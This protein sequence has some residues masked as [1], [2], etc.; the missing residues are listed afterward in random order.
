MKKNIAFLM[1]EKS[2]IFLR[3]K[4]KIKFHKGFFI[5]GFLILA[6]VFFVMIF[7]IR[8]NQEIE[9]IARIDS[10]ILVARDLAY[11]E[12]S[13]SGDLATQALI[14]SLEINYKKGQADSYRLNSIVTFL[15]KDYLTSIEYLE[16]SIEL[17]EEMKDSVG[18]ADANISYGHIYRDFNQR[19]KG[20]FHF[21]KAFDFFAK[22][23][24]PERISVT[25]Y[26]YANIL[27]ENGKWEK[28]QE[29]VDSAIHQESVKENIS[30]YIFFLNLRAKILIQSGLCH[31]AL[32]DLNLAK[33]KSLELKEN[34]NK[35]AFIET[36]F[37]L[38]KVFHHLDDF[39]SSEYYLN[40]AKNDP[41]ISYAENYSD[42]V[43]I[44]LINLNITKNDVSNVKGEMKKFLELKSINKG[45]NFYDNNEFKFSVIVNKNRVKE[46]IELRNRQ[47]L[48][49]LYSS[50]YL[51]IIFIIFITFTVYII[52]K[53]KRDRFSSLLDGQKRR[54][55]NLFENSPLPILIV[56]NSGNILLS[57]DRV[58]QFI[59]LYG[60]NMLVNL[61]NSVLN[62][63][64]VKNK[65][66][67]D[68]NDFLEFENGDLHI[69]VYFIFECN[70][71]EYTI[72]LEDLSVLKKSIRE[73]ENLIE[74]LNQ[75]YKLA[76]IGSFSLKINQDFN[77]DID[78]ISSIALTILGFPADYQGYNKHSLSDLF[79]FGDLTELHNLIVKASKE[80]NYFDRVVKLKVHPSP[81]RW[82]RI[83]GRVFESS[84]SKFYMKGIIQDVTS[85][86]RWMVSTLENLQREKELNLVKSRFISMTSHEF[87]TP[88][89]VAS[90]SI[91]MI[92]IHSDSIENLDLRNKVLNH[93]SKISKQLNKIVLLL[94]DILIME[95]TSFTDKNLNLENISL[96]EFLENIID[97]INST[98]SGRKIQLL[99]AG[100]GFKFQTD[101]VLFEYL[102][103]NLLTNAIKFSGSDKNCLVEVD[104]GANHKIIKVTDFGLGIP[105][106]EIPLVFN[107]FFRASNSGS[108]KGTGLG[109]S[110]VMEICKKLNYTIKVDSVVNQKTTFILHVN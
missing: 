82:A 26:N 71:R 43:F 17:F 51:F 4:E 110:I 46:N 86:R 14:E 74:L 10:L 37:Y 2:S 58:K 8:S 11:I 83:I 109:L 19:D 73:Q 36:L 57:N 88:I 65:S 60:E 12:R 20:E 52:G 55:V 99:R 100:S 105:E 77:L 69:R 94:D 40:Y 91:D 103:N 7:S 30:L 33:R 50:I 9:K 16:L 28:S 21:K 34:R 18:L 106:K 56:N 61:I 90:S 44:D 48:S 87:R 93:S 22:Q 39:D 85:E 78:V 89:A 47:Y 54:Y 5:A 98:L 25:A 75:S 79:E 95:R 104:F 72:L 29:I 70:E 45:L 62:R 42:S 101:I 96:D 15:D 32:D 66:Y 35:T 102:I 80:E 3:I 76:N 24:I 63:Y 13:T 38:G 23:G 31:L 68:G 92:E 6:S 107:S 97:E 67:L 49:S 41:Y 1:N 64:S 59:G 84:D 53:R 108:V 27:F 81:N